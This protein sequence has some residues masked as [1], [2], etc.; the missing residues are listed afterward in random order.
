MA[1]GSMCGFHIDQVAR[2]PKSPLAKC[3]PLGFGMDSWALFCRWPL[4]LWV[5]MAPVSGARQPFFVHSSILSFISLRTGLNHQV[6]FPRIVREPTTVYLNTGAEPV[7][8]V[9]Q[10]SRPPVFWCLCP[11]IPLSELS[12]G[13][14]WAF[15]SLLQMTGHEVY[16]KAHFVILSWL[17][18]SYYDSELKSQIP[19]ESY[20]PTCSHIN[21]HSKGNKFKIGIQNSKFLV[22]HT[23]EDSH[24][25]ISAK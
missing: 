11:W 6:G 7:G 10:D 19:F 18:F 8:M 20:Q 3:P 2:T 23:P 13:N 1:W 24:I 25:C 17:S 4:L 22:E 12:G 16:A 5:R 14:V 21:Q 15:G 9:V